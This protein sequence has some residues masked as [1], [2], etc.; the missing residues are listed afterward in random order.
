APARLGAAR[1]ARYLVGGRLGRGIEPR[2]RSEV[3]RRNETDATAAAPERSI[4]RTCRADFRRHARRPLDAHSVVVGQS[5]DSATD[6]RFADRLFG[7]LYRV[8]QAP[9]A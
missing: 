7:P 1:L 2:T 3:R 9:H 5:A 6:V 8:A 4:D